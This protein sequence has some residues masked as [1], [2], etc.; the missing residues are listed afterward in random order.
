LAE[1]LSESNPKIS[2]PFIRALGSIGTRNAV[3]ADALD[4]ALTGK[5]GTQPKRVT[6]TVGFAYLW[7]PFFFAASKRNEAQNLTLDDSLE[8]Y[9]AEKIT[10][11]DGQHLRL[12]LRAEVPSK[13]AVSLKNVSPSDGTGS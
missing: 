4:I 3:L 12:I 9:G 5:A 10:G 6:G 8:I 11:P 7:P 1:I 13:I 2:F